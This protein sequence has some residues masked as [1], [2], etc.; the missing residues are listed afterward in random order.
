MSS[1]LLRL[2]ALAVGATLA[3]LIAGCASTD[4]GPRSTPS[5]SAQ[6]SSALSSPAATASEP[7]LSSLVASPDGLGYLAP[8]VAVPAV[9]GATAIL[10]FDPTKCVTASSGLAAGSPGA[11]AWVPRYPDALTY[12]GSGIP[13]D[14]GAVGSR[15]DPIALIEIWSPEITT[16]KGVGDGST[17]AQL[18]AAYGSALTVDHADNSDVYVLSGARAKLLFE[19]A[20]AGA[21]LPVEE[22]GTVVWMRIVP[23][24]DTQLHIANS[25]AS[26]VCGS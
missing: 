24:G 12:A 13:F 8:G 4:G 18:E 14:V 3:L 20:K 9:P 11:G 1:S 23:L 19:V 15:T 21:G 10:D 25:D 26:G 16:A 17:P 2:G 5:A 22:T 7:S 6:S